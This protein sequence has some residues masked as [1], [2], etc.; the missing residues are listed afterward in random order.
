VSEGLP[1]R[2]RLCFLARVVQREARYLL[3]TD[4]R[5]FAAPLTLAD[6]AALPGR[7]ELSERVDAFV[8]RLSRLQDGC[9]D[10]LL[11]ALLAALGETPGP[12]IDNLNRAERLGWL[13]SSTAWMTT[14]R[15]RN[16]MV[17][18]Y[19][20]DASVLLDALGSAHDAVPALAAA[21]G[22]LVDEVERR[23]GPC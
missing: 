22:R 14:R 13:D 15:L 9:A 20:E 1:D 8:A 11:P 21:A 17:H 3:E 2:A 7:P 19:V 10:K 12:T 5:L 6:M 18:E 16:R 23:F 4:Q